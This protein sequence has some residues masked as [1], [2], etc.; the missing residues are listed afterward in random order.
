MVSGLFLRTKRPHQSFKLWYDQ[1]IASDSLSLH[2]Y[3]KLVLVCS[4]EE[5]TGPL[6]KRYRVRRW[7][8]LTLPGTG[9]TRFQGL[10][11][12]QRGSAF[13]R[14]S[15]YLFTIGRNG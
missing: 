7:Y 1:K 8:N 12:P 5:V 9:D 3:D 6:C 14:P 2:L 10:C 13:T 15:R 11:T 4:E